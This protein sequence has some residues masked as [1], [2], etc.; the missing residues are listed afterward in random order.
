[1]GKSIFGVQRCESTWHL[2]GGGM[3]LVMSFSFFGMFKSQGNL[4]FGL[5]NTAN[6]GIRGK[7]HSAF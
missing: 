6:V 2:T 5:L 4:S 3:E 7:L 1:M